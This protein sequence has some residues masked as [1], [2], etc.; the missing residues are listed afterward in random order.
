MRNGLVSFKFMYESVLG[1]NLTA[2]VSDRQVTLNWEAPEG[3]EIEKYN[4]YRDGALIQST[5]QTTFRET[6]PGRGTYKY[7]VSIKYASGEES[8]QEEVKVVIIVSGINAIEKTPT[9]IY[10]NPVEKGEE[11]VINL[12]G[13]SEK[14]DLLFYDISGRLLLNKQATTSV[15]RH[16]L[17]LPAGMYMLKIVTVQGTETIKFYMK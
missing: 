6:L 14:A 13:D 11:L 17:H 2:T 5:T 7:G 8:A 3:Q 4:I 12:G 9:S 16:L 15:S 1:I 10:P